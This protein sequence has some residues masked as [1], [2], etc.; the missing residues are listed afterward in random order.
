MQPKH[1]L[2]EVVSIVS[3]NQ[4]NPRWSN[5]YDFRLSILNRGTSAGDL[6]STPSRGVLFFVL[7]FASFLLEL[8]FMRDRAKDRATPKYTLYA[9]CQP[10]MDGT[11][12]CFCQRSK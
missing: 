9:S 7:F 2:T 4:S 3:S 5:G 1:A 11:K 6:G 12:P 10:N 8:G